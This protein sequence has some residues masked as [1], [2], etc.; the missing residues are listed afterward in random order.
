MDANGH[1]ETKP[2]AAPK[3]SGVKLTQ[4]YA[5]KG[6][7]RIPRNNL[8][9]EPPDEFPFKGDAANNS[10]PA[11]RALQQAPSSWTGI[12]LLQR[13][14]SL[15]VATSPTHIR[16]HSCL[17]AVGPGSFSVICVNLRLSAVVLVVL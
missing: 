17:F 16:V 13:D 8:K 2:T 6:Q 5:D 12:S 3:S 11:G 10:D 1:E 7:R 15:P 4:I 14:P 9:M